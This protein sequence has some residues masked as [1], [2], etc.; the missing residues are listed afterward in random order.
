MG[1]M[2]QSF[3][4]ATNGPPAACA[5]LLSCAIETQLPKV[6]G[7]QFLRKALAAISVPALHK[8]QNVEL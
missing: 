8:L 7:K 3:V 6:R 2:R 1:A 4:L 5:L